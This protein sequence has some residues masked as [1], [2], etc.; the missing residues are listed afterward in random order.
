MASCTKPMVAFLNLR[1]TFN[2]PLKAFIRA[3]LTALAAFSTAAAIALAFFTA[4]SFTLRATSFTFFAAFSAAAATF[5]ACG[6]RVQGK[7]PGSRLRIIQR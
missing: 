3:A 7:R 5:F 2:S 6:S 1:Y 4:F